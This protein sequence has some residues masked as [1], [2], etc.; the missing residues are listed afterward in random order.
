MR[1]IVWEDN[2]FRAEIEVI[3]RQPFMHLEVFNWSKSVAIKMYEQFELAQKLLYIGGARQ[4]FS[5][6]PKSEAKIIKFNRMYGMRFLK[7]HGDHIIMGCTL[8]APEQ[9][10]VKD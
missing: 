3:N 9:S 2:D 10:Q 6:I 8:H 7:E 4:L 1:Y 5:L